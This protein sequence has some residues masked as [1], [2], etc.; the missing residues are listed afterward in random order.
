MWPPAAIT[1]SWLHKAVTKSHDNAIVRLLLAS[2]TG[3]KRKSTLTHFLFIVE[4]RKNVCHLHVQIAFAANV[5]RIDSR[6]EQSHAMKRDM[7]MTIYSADLWSLLKS[8]DTLH[9][10]RLPPIPTVKSWKKSLIWSHKANIS[11][12]TLPTI[13]YVIYTCLEWPYVHGYVP[14]IV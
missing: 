9:I 2:K 1:T 11:I 7:Y 8:N 5:S 6:Y 4:H 12:T 13:N 10:K 14:L 3:V